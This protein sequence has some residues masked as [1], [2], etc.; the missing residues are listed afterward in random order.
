MPFTAVDLHTENIGMQL[1]STVAIVTVIIYSNTVSCRE[2]G[3]LGLR[4]TLMTL[5]M[6]LPWLLKLRIMAIAIQKNLDGASIKR[7]SRIQFAVWGACCLI[8]LWPVKWVEIVRFQLGLDGCYLLDEILIIL[9]LIFSWD[10]V[11]LLRQLL[12]SQRS[13]AFWPNAKMQSLALVPV[14]GILLVQDIVAAWPLFRPF[15]K[16]IY[17]VLIAGI[18]FFLPWMLAAIWKLAPLPIGPVRDVVADTVRRAETRFSQLLLWESGNRLTNAAVCGLVPWLRYLLISDG[19]IGRLSTIELRAVVAHEIAHVKHRHLVYS[20]LSLLLPCL[21]IVVIKQMFVTQ[22]THDGVD[23]VLISVAMSCWLLIHR[24]ICRCFEHHA[25]IEACRI[26]MP[27][28]QITLDS[29]C[30]GELSDALKKLNF[31]EEDGSDWWHPS[32]SFRVRVLEACSTSPAIAQAFEM[33]ITTIQR[34]II[35]TVSFLALVGA[36]LVLIQV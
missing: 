19:L 7:L 25:D 18:P 5:A 9:P 15:E 27:N 4:L 33:R 3:D 6:F 14:A 28:N 13:G 31:G 34:A 29:Q 22:T 21:S 17:L 26:L 10:V 1:F 30:V 23:Y 36:G 35:G 16:P 32:T 12:R 20:C 11:G 8:I 24:F 2:I